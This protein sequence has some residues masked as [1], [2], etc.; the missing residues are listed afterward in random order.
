MTREGCVWPLAEWLP[1]RYLGRSFSSVFS[2]P[3][4]T[5]MAGAVKQANDKMGIIGDGPL[6][7]QASGGGLGWSGGMGARSVA[8]RYAVGWRVG[9]GVVF[10]SLEERCG[11]M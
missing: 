8:T 2:C 1:I 10:R 11:W 9:K 5:S 4:A 6:P 7:S 3:Q